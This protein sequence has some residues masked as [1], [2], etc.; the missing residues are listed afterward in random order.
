MWFTKQKANNSGAEE[1]LCP[2]DELLGSPT[3]SML[4]HPHRCQWTHS[5]NFPCVTLVI[6]VEKKLNVTFQRPLFPLKQWFLNKTNHWEKNLKNKK[7]NKTNHWNSLCL[8][9]LP[10]LHLG[11]H[12]LF[13]RGHLSKLGFMIA[14]YFVRETGW[15]F[16][17]GLR[18]HL[19]TLSTKHEF[20]SS[21]CTFKVKVNAYPN[22]VYV[23]WLPCIFPVTDY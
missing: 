1:P 8:C 22:N 20:F 14:H 12:N 2:A 5:K 15:R 17:D 11:F 19:I 4:P 9:V 7:I 6:S 18:L 23:R 16:H 10:P 13:K 21:G 3:E